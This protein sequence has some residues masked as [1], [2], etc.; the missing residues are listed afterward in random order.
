[1]RA[2]VLP[3]TQNTHASAGVAAN[4]WANSM[5]SWDFLSLYQNLPGYLFAFENI[6]YTTKSYY[7]DATGWL[8]TLAADLVEDVST[9]DECRIVKVR[10][11]REWRRG[12]F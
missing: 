7:S 4:R 8:G 2:C 5:A 11:R 3:W 6:P 9:V 1:M 12:R 10:D